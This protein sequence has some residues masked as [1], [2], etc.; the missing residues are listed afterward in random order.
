MARFFGC[1]RFGH[2]GSFDME[3]QYRES[4]KQATLSWRCGRVCPFMKIKMRIGRISL[5]WLP[6]PENPETV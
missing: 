3:G 5:I 1:G 2:F 6:V 4:K